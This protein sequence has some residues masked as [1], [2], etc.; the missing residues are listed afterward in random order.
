MT[1]PAARCGLQQSHSL[2]SL[3]QAGVCVVLFP[4]QPKPLEASVTTG[5]VRDYFAMAEEAYSALHAAE[6]TVS[7][8]KEEVD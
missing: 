1:P 6:A 8:A 7:Q 5:W 4:L 3:S 2:G